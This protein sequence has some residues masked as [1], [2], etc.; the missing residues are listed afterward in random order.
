MSTAQQAS[1]G[2]RT[3]GVFGWHRQ[4][5]A[6]GAAAASDVMLW[7]EDAA[8]AESVRSALDAVG[9]AA[10]VAAGPELA[11]FAGRA[12]AV[13]DLA[14]SPAGGIESALGF[15]EHLAGEHPELAAVVVVEEESVDVYRWA[16]QSGI[17]QVV[18]RPEGPER[19]VEAVRAARR[20]AGAAPNA[21]EARPAAVWTVFGAQG[22]IGKTTLA[23][24][25]AAALA[26]RGRPTAV[27]DLNAGLGV[28]HVFLDLQPRRPVTEL[29]SDIRRLDADLLEEYML[30]HSSGLRLLPAPGG[31]DLAGF[32]TPEHVEQILAVAG[33]RFDQIILDMPS[34]FPAF[35]APALRR[36][37]GLLLTAAPDLV[38]L[39]LA[40]LAV[41]GTVGAQ[42]DRGRV[43][44][45]LRE[46]E[47][48]D[49]L[50]PQDIDTALHMPVWARLPWAGATTT[51][52]LNRGTP[53]VVAYPRS[54]YAAAVR[55]IVE[56]LS[57]ESR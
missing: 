11:R 49:G 33:T 24:N 42:V 7:T 25:L 54:R 12:V 43:R 55:R 53:A 23:V 13:F 5:P 2:A 19:V 20:A 44:L 31:A 28:A 26:A 41:A 8:W 18:H 52:A 57:K 9:L 47:R 16:M 4:A 35:A 17:R 29:L 45:V 15:A 40:Q 6:T 38:G 1:G 46:T 3:R 32:V 22:G 27:L 30:R 21:P 36:S 39:A 50:T 14:H 10:A 51:P 56:L 34:G 48:R 37:T